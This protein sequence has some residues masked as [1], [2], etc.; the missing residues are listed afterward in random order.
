MFLPKQTGEWNGKEK[1]MAP[2]RV[3]YGVTINDA[4]KRGDKAEMKALLAEAKRT[5]KAQGNLA[6][7]I[8]KLQVAVQKPIKIKDPGHIMYG[9]PVFD[10]IKRGNTAE[11]KA[12][13]A[14][15]KK[16][17]KD[18][19]DLAKAIKNLESAMKKG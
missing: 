4:I 14:Q 17:R 9:V 16:T 6:V 11:M 7:A 2:I 8:S 13:L 1:T 18:Q 5:H 15:A 12:L 10:A 19:G 3:L